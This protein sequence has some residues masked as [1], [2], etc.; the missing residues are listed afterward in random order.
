MYGTHLPLT[1]QVPCCPQLVLQPVS[2]MT[3]LFLAL[4]PLFTLTCFYFSEKG[5]LCASL[6]EAP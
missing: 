1:W 4:L 3:L 6:A 5:V 2:V